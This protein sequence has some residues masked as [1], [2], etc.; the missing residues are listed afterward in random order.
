MGKEMN[1][2]HRHLEF[3]LEEIEDELVK[4]GV[5]VIGMVIVTRAIAIFNCF[6]WRGDKR[7]PLDPKGR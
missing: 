3:S 4:Y 7:V 5:T 1:W 2:R 6:L